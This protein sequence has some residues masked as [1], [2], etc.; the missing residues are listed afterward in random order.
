MV[1]AW[2]DEFLDGS[3]HVRF[4]QLH[5]TR[6]DEIVAEARAQLVH[7]LDHD[8]VALFEPRTVGEDNYPCFSAH[9][10]GS[11]SDV[12]DEIKRQYVNYLFFKADP[13]WRRLAR[14]ERERGKGEFEGV[15]KDWK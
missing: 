7:E 5:E 1:A 12:G 2:L 11:M 6:F 9:T 13:A 10:A 3:G 8:F 15:I 14:D 4:A